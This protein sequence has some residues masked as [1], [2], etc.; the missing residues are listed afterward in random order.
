MEEHQ[1]KSGYKWTQCSLQNG[2]GAA[3]ISKRIAK[4]EM[5]LEKSNKKFQIQMNMV[6]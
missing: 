4:D 2:R 5:Q 6:S 3:G 1:Q